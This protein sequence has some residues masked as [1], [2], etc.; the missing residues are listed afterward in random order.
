MASRTTDI[1][2]Q[3]AALNSATSPIESQTS[4]LSRA[5]S[6][7]NDSVAAKTKA[8]ADAAAAKKK[9]EEDAAKTGTAEFTDADGYSYKLTWTAPSLTVATDASQGKPG[10]T[11]VSVS[12]NGD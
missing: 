8:D 6:A 7:V 9:A 4:A 5:Y 3:T 11:R 1:T 10:T 12:T 2:D